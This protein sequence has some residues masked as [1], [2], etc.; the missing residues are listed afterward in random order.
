M[1][2]VECRQS[3]P[4]ISHRLP[5]PPFFFDFPP[6]PP[7]SAFPAAG[8]PGAGAGVVAVAVAMAAEPLS[9][10]AAGVSALSISPAVPPLGATVVP[11][12]DSIFAPLANFPKPEIKRP[13]SAA[14]SVRY[15]RQMPVEGL[16]VFKVSDAIGIVVAGSA[17]ARLSDVSA[18]LR[19][20]LERAFDS[21]RRDG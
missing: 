19:G 20:F 21:R 4:P 7:V 5:F 12:S 11:G 2:K 10:A 1:V 8:G 3:K 18:A 13:T 14:L 16:Y 6:F 9:P 15:L 17:D